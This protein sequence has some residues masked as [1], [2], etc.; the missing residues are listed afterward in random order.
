MNK[1]TDSFSLR[2]VVEKVCAGFAAAAIIAFV[3][4]GAVAM[5]FP[6]IA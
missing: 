1:P 6:N 5:C 2:S 4:A 3:S